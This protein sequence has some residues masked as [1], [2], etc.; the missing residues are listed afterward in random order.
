MSR[1]LAA[2]KEA[3]RTI[4]LLDDVAKGVGTFEVERY[5]DAVA[6]LGTLQEAYRQVREGT[7]APGEL[8]GPP[9]DGW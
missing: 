4:R 2:H 9:D 1:L 6:A 7:F 3:L 8:P 5:N